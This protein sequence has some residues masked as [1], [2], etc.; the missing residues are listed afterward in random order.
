[1]PGDQ[2]FM[3]T[4]R[5]RVANEH[6]EWGGMGLGLPGPEG[7]GTRGRAGPARLG[8]DGVSEVSEGARASGDRCTALRAERADSTPEITP[9]ARSRE[10]TG[11]APAASLPA[12]A[13]GLVVAA[14]RLH[15]RAAG[16]AGGRRGLRVRARGGLPAPVGAKSPCA[17]GARVHTTLGGISP[18]GDPEAQ[19][20]Q[21]GFHRWVLGTEGQ[22]SLQKFHLLFHFGCHEDFTSQCK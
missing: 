4:G 19:H 15:N 8:T 16:L 10:V 3:E 1:M 18:L 20:L 22:P 21:R 12:P 9:E 6:A 17:S 11:C 7:R 13:G 2:V 14:P 5:P